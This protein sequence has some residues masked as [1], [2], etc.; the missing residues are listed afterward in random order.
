VY[1]D[2][3]RTSAPAAYDRAGFEIERLTQALQVAHGSRHASIRQTGTLGALSAMTLAGLIPEEISRELDHAYVFMR[4]AEHRRQLGL[5]DANLEK[6]VQA[7]QAR[8]REL[9]ATVGRLGD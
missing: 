5:G 8:V 6:Q 9:C 3:P 4:T 1:R 2:G 7:S